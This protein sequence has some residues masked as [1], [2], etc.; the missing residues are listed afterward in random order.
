MRIPPYLRLQERNRKRRRVK[1]AD[2]FLA[3]NQQGILGHGAYSTA[4]A[5]GRSRVL[6]VTD[7][8]DITRLWLW[9]YCRRISNPHW[10]RTMWLIRTKY[11]YVTLM[12]RLYPLNSST[13]HEVECADD[14]L[15]C[16]QHMTIGALREFAKLS[17]LSAPWQHCPPRLGEALVNC[18]QA[19]ID[20]GFRIDNKRSA[21]MRRVGAILI[22]IDPF[23]VR[24]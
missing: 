4:F 16:C 10:P 13:G 7:V 19:A 18:H 21:Y 14:L 12:E 15:S 17:D 2:R 11:H 5:V 22:P 3:A 6:K 20:R 23:M 24:D 8:K 9:K 1:V